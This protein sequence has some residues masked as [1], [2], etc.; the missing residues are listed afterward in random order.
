MTLAL[1]IGRRFLAAFGAVLAMILGI[2]LLF[3]MIE[4]LRRSASDGQMSFMFLLGMS[5]LKLP[6]GMNAVLPFAVMIGGIVAFWWLSRSHELVVMRAAGISA[7]QFLLPLLVIVLGIGVN[8]PLS[9]SENGLW[10]RETIGQ[11]L[12][13]VHAGRVRQEG[14]VL[15]L[16]DVSIFLFK[17]QNG[18]QER[19]EAERGVLRND[20][21]YELYQVRVMRTEKPPVHHTVL[22]LPTTL[23]VGRIQENFASPETVSVWA[24]PGFI[25]FFEQSGFSARAHRLHLQTLMAAPF[26][27]CA[28]VLAAAVFVMP[29]NQRKGSMLWR[30]AGATATGFVVYFFSKVTHALG[31]SATL[32]VVLAAWSPTLIMGLLGLGAVFYF[33]DG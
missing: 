23:T 26:L 17:E 16:Y 11:Y 24:L 31:Q 21:H 15:F 4:L 25:R 27:L 22:R 29:Q 32:P 3:D 7:W 28:M 12:S 1:Y 13:V 9:L 6:Q 30:I 10:L 8:N 14:I 18:F 19:I 20:G 2:V 33:E 5:F